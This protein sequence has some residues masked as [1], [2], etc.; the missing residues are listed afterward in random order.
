MRLLSLC[1]GSNEEDE[2]REEAEQL[3]DSDSGSDSE[4]GE[5]EEEEG[6]GGGAAAVTKGGSPAKRRRRRRKKRRGDKPPPVAHRAWG[7]DQGGGADGVDAEGNLLPLAHGAAP[8]A[9]RAVALAGA[10]LLQGSPGGGI[11]GGASQRPRPR[12]AA[13][14]APAVVPQ[15]AASSPLLA[16]PS[17]PRLT[18]DELRHIRQRAASMLSERSKR[19]GECAARAAERAEREADEERARREVREAQAERVRVLRSGHGREQGLT[20]EKFERLIQARVRDAAELPPGRSFS[21]RLG[22]FAFTDERARRLNARQSKFAAIFG[23]RHDEYDG[24]E[25]DPSQR[26][27]DMYVEAQHGD[28]RMG[29]MRAAHRAEVEAREEAAAAREAGKQAARELRVRH[30]EAAIR[31]ARMRVGDSGAARARWI[32]KRS[33]ARAAEGDAWSNAAGARLGATVA[34]TPMSPVRDPIRTTAEALDTLGDVQRNQR[35]GYGSPS[36]ARGGLFPGGSEAYSG[37]DYASGMG[38]PAR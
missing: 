8:T 27:T 12:Q 31:A 9:G 11:D 2:Q 25:A 17:L 14:M 28:A 36:P 32:A 22:D 6:E 21:A 3:T 38:S 37:S 35:Q 5:E 33:L 26:M 19:A 30:E 7:L 10:P 23:M 29:T 13:A 34:A 24:F 16:A 4:G 20:R 15:S 1:F 18:D